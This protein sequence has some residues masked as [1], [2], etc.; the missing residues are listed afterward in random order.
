M[1]S[2]HSTILSIQYSQ[3]A[4]LCVVA[5]LQLHQFE[6]KISC[7]GTMRR[8]EHPP[9]PIGNEWRDLDLMY[10]EAI[11]RIPDVGLIFSTYICMDNTI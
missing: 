8:L 3:Q 7:S 10:C 11:I 2:F 1:Q 4:T 9:K 6:L 5:G